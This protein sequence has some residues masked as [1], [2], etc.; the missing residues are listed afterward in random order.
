MKLKSFVA[1]LLLI[2]AA[3]PSA[4]AAKNKTKFVP[5]KDLTLIGKV[6]PTPDRYARVDTVKYDGFTDYQ[7]RSLNQESSGLALVFKTNSDRVEVNFDY[8]KRHH[9]YNGTDVASAGA[10]LYIKRDG[11]WVYAG[12]GVPSAKG[13]PVALVSA[14]APGEKECLLYMPLRSI[15]DEVYVGISPDATITPMENPFKHKIV[16]WGSSFTHGVSAN[17]SGMAYPL[18]LQRATG[19]DIR[20]LGVSGNSKLQQ[21]YARVLADSDADAFVFDAFS[22]PQAPEIRGEL[23][24]FRKDHPRQAPCHPDYL[25]AD[26]LPRKPQFQHRQRPEGGRQ[27]GRRRGDGAQGHGDRP[28]HLHRIS[29]GR[30]RRLDLHR[31]DPPPR[32]WAT[33]TGW[34]RYASR[35]LTSSPSTT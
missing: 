21:S 18:Q 13:E 28:Q 32:I 7:R 24:R 9:A 12:S 31:Q 8:K 17:R 4:Y 23:Q 19:L 14:M 22:N 25:P 27:D 1:A 11:K 16:F 6:M 20:S 2:A 33:T 30:Y 15:I 3:L 35:Y 34:S 5:G 26:H 10:D 29:C